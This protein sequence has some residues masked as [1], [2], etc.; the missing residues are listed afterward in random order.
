ME[1]VAGKLDQDVAGNEIQRTSGGRSVEGRPFW[2][3]EAWLETIWVLGQRLRLLEALGTHGEEGE[4]VGGREQEQ[5]EE[6]T[7]EDVCRLVVERS[8]INSGL[9]NDTK[10]LLDSWTANQTSDDEEDDEEQGDDE[11]DWLLR[12]DRLGK[13]LKTFQRD[14]ISTDKKV[15]N[16]KK[17]S[18]PLRKRRRKRR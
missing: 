9:L 11:N 1:R 7:L 3:R 6:V 4:E 17:S 16:V 14:L 18:S 12:F 15:E 8:E 2:R 5:K 10:N 13:Q